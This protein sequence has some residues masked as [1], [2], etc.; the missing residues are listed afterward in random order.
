MH[1]TDEIHQQ[2]SETT[3]VSRLVTSTLPAKQTTTDHYNKISHTFQ[4]LSVSNVCLQ[5][6]YRH[7]SRGVIV[8][9]HK[10]CR[11]AW[12]SSMHRTE[13]V[14]V[15]GHELTMGVS[16]TRLVK[17]QQNIFGRIL[18][19]WSVGS[20]AQRHKIVQ[21]FV[22]SFKQDV[23]CVEFSAKLFSWVIV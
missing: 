23:Q 15:M 6:S 1:L 20:M 5:T 10:L 13:S 7:Y 3:T 2:A 8:V 14:S 19:F 12:S 21:Q 18:L 4:V 11:T 16:S 17:K 9:F 22:Y